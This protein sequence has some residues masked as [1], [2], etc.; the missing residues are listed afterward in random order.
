MFELRI[1]K[2]K[3]LCSRACEEQHD[4]EAIGNNPHIF[5][6]LEY[7]RNQVTPVVN[8]DDETESKVFRQLCA[9]LCVMDNMTDGNTAKDKGFF[10]I[11]KSDGKLLL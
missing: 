2:L 7:L 6:A 9:T 5:V 3:E 1:Q 4:K 11:I 10:N 8:H